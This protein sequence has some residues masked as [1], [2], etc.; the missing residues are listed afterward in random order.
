[1]GMEP[2]VADKLIAATHKVCPYSNATRGN[3][4]VKLVRV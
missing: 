4:D 1:P 2:D 3:I